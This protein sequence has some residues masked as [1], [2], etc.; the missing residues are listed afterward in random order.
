LKVG[1]KGEEKGFNAEDA[2]FAEKRDGNTSTG[3]GQEPFTEG[4]TQRAQRKEGEKKRR[5]EEKK[6]RRK[7]E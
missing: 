6:E 7:E 5:R 4:R 3:S 1:R 2:E